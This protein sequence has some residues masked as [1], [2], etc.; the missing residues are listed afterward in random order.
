[1][2]ILWLYV[3]SLS[4]HS[5]STSY[6]ITSQ[7]SIEIEKLSSKTTSYPKT[8]MELT[9]M[10]YPRVACI[11]AAL[12]YAIVFIVEKFRPWQSDIH[13]ASSMSLH[14]FAWSP[15]VFLFCT[16]LMIRSVA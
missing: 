9:G 13:S 3:W 7:Y 15:V 6:S 11:F 10:D 1:M 8:V 16:Q 14:S 12:L 4:L 2:D 5:A